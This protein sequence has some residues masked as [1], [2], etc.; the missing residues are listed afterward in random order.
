MTRGQSHSGF[1]FIEVMV[2]MLIFVMAVLAAVDIVN[3]SV[4][5]TKESKEITVA[6][7]LLQ[8]VMVDLETKIETEGFDK[9]CEKKKEGTFESPHESF[10]WKT[11]CEE[12]D[13][14]LSQT[15]SQLAGTDSSGNESATE[16]QLQ[17]LILDTASKYITKAL[18]EL[19]AEVTWTQGKDK[20]TIDL[21]T[22]FARFD[23]PLTI[24]GI[25]GTGGTPATGGGGGT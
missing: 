19:H 13:F 3:G 12:I 6:T 7:Q 25:P 16:N 10:S 21:T 9:G 1:T 14:N 22:H 2:A 20:R 23:Q 24:G 17:K 15:A 5:A 18:R 8:N 11:F 4:R